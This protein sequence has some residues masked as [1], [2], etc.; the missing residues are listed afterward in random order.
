MAPSSEEVDELADE[1]DASEDSV[2]VLWISSTAQ[3]RRRGKRRGEVSV[4]EGDSDN[5]EEHEAHDA[6]TDSD[7]VFTHIKWAKPSGRLR[8]ASMARAPPP[9]PRP[10]LSPSN[11]A[12]REAYLASQEKSTPQDAPPKVDCLEIALDSHGRP[13][14]A[15][16]EAP[17]VGQTRAPCDVPAYWRLAVVVG[18]PS[19]VPFAGRVALSR[20]ADDDYAEENPWTSDVLH[21]PARFYPERRDC[22]GPSQQVVFHCVEVDEGV[23]V[24][25]RQR[26]QAGQG[27]ETPFEAGYATTAQLG[28]RVRLHCPGAA[29]NC[30]PVSSCCRSGSGCVDGQS[31]DYTLDKPTTPRLS[32]RL[33]AGLTVTT[34]I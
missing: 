5:N 16:E 15:E 1:S 4:R 21:R 30:M 22:D 25:E 18:C 19:P 11:R 29:M 8:L 9:R 31:A 13:G 28:G 23:V 10:R 33:V 7:V 2:V 12:Q 3:G 6:S 17:A 34:S 26:G 14:Q 24:V 32:V 20:L 27:E